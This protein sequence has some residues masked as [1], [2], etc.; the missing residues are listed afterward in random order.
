MRRLAHATL[1]LAAAVLLATCA[2]AP[3][4]PPDTSVTNAELGIR[5]AAVPEGFEVA[6]SEGAVLELRPVGGIAGGSVLF[7]VGPEETG[8]NLVAA[9]KAHQAHIEGLPGGEYQGAQELQGPLGTA[10]YSR[11]RYQGADGLEEETVILSLHPSQSRLLEITYD[12]PA[13]DDSAARVKELIGVLA[14]VEGTK[15]E[16]S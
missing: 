7:A 5:L 12:Y 2:P 15:P 10:F 16:G 6:R 8:V 1:A 14:Q 4:T 9:V 13:G 11:G 3:T